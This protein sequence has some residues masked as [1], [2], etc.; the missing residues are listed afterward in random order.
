MQ[1]TSWYIVISVLFQYG[2]IHDNFI[3]FGVWLQP[4]TFHQPKEICHLW[5]ENPIE[6]Y[7]VVAY[8]M[9]SLVFLEA[10]QSSILS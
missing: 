9:H 1:P 4:L 5:P 3:A 2:D 7:P 6:T 10:L 8:R